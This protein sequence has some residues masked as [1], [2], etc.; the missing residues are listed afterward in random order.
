MDDI[1]MNFCM[2]MM[3][4]MYQHGVRQAP[5]LSPV[6][7]EPS[8]NKPISD[9][10]NIEQHHSAYSTCEESTI[11]PTALIDPLA[12][13]GQNVHIGAYS[14]I[15][16]GMCIWHYDLFKFNSRVNWYRCCSR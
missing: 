4:F 16:P 3:G 6:L 5:V 9:V 7:Q 13:L 14:I 2:L 1:I 15:G 8:L 12:K 11:H 10:A